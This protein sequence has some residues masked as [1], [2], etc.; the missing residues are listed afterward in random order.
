MDVQLSKEGRASVVIVYGDVDTS[1][2]E[3]L[4]RILDPL[5]ETVNQKLLIDLSDV[6][7]MDS[8][9]ISV[10][11]IAHKR[12]KANRGD[13]RFCSLSPQ[14]EMVFQVTRLDKQ[15]DVFSSRA[16]ALEKW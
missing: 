11:I 13:I 7:F 15:F 3:T 10:L 1:N 8:S 14:L 12:V 6:K 5:V 4:A 9:G 2:S 16:A